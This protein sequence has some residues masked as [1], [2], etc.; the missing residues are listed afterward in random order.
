VL[1][2]VAAAGFAAIGLDHYT[3]DGHEPDQVASALGAAGLACSDV[4]IVRIGELQRADL[5]QL[6]AT[7]VA[8]A[9]G[10]CIAALYRPLPHDDVVR[11]LR[12]MASYCADRV[13]RRRLVVGSAPSSAPCNSPIVGNADPIGNFPGKNPPT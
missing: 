8:L 6:A 5:E 1:D 11:E 10:L 9:C 7:A 12:A 4:G 2:G 13:P 3:L